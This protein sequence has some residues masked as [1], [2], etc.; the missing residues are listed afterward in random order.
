[1]IVPVVVE[2]QS[3]RWYGRIPEI[4]DNSIEFVQL[5]FRFPEDWDGM[6]IVAQFTQTQTYN[7][8]LVNNRCFLPME[9][10]AGPCEVSVFGYLN[11]E[12]TRGTTIPLKLN[13]SRSGFVSSAE[14]PIP[15]TPDLYA[16]L[17]E[18]FS[19]IAGSGGGGSGGGTINPED[20]AAAVEDY[21]SKNPPDV[22]DLS[23]EVSR[24]EE[25]ASNAEAAADRAEE[26]AKVTTDLDTTLT[27]EGKAADAKAV[28]DA[29]SKL[30]G[31]NVDYVLPV[32]GDELGG[33]KNGGNVT[34]NADGTMTAPENE[35]SG[36]QV[37]NAVSD[38][39][40]AH[41][42]ATTTV[43]AGSIDPNKTTWMKQA[44]HNIFDASTSSVGKGFYYSG[45]EM[46]DQAANSV[47]A[48]IPVKAGAIYRVV[49]VTN[50]R[51]LDS[52]KTCIGSQS[53]NGT[54]RLETA[55]EGAAYALMQYVTANA[56]S[57]QVHEY[58]GE[59]WKYDTY[60]NLRTIVITE[61]AYSKA[62][63]DVVERGFL[64]GSL[65]LQDGTV[66][67]DKTTWMRRVFHN[68]FDPNDP[69][70]Q[71]G[72]YYFT[73]GSDV[74]TG[75][76]T[77]NY[78]LSGYIPVIGGK[79]YHIN[80]N[81]H[82][83]FF[84]EAKKFLSTGSPKNVPD[85]ASYMRFS[86]QKS[87]MTVDT[88][89]VYE[90]IGEEWEYDTYKNLYSIV[91]TDPSYSGAIA[92]MVRGKFADG[93]LTP[94]NLFADESL[95]YKQ[96]KGWKEFHWNIVDPATVTRT[97][98]NQYYQYHTDFC[99]VEPGM[100][101]IGNYTYDFY[102]AN[103]EKVSSQA[104]FYDGGIHDVIVPDGVSFVKV[105]SGYE[106][107]ENGTIRILTPGYGKQR[108]DSDYDKSFPVFKDEDSKEG[109]K[110]YLGLYPW[111]GKNFGII[112]DS[113]TAP[114]TWCGIMADN[115]KAANCWNKAVSGANFGDVDGV[116]KTAYEQAQELVSAGNTLDVVLITMGTNDANNGRT[117]G[118]IVESNSISDFD[119]STYTG[120]LQA[121]LNCLQ[122]NFPEA[123]I[124]VGWTP[125]GGLVNGTKVEYITRMQEVCLMYGVEYIETRTCGV[126]R[127][128]DVY[129]ECYEGGTGGGH[130]TG[131]GQQK[132][133]EYMTRLMKSKL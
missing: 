70:I 20:I 119:L 100:T 109:F 3:L 12:V 62:I 110:V 91:I 89:Q 95:R 96:M 72:H 61:D 50:I 58:I 108:G 23:E 64:D 40:D 65:T 1:M 76:G 92:D 51:W 126:T 83:K 125:M 78:F 116:P 128:S 86:V 16:Q 77:A 44:H 71:D 32:G 99:E 53:A 82:L 47:S 27:Q 38:W 104:A 107:N 43:A 133:G 98:P 57:V 131:A 30:S 36:E 80:A 18:Y 54:D 63:A 124:Y 87:A 60:K 9:L 120:G 114:G 117:M 7:C 42:E 13:I 75:G 129:A 45:A 19:S 90:D 24:A 103:K 94:Y 52:A 46:N 106:T 115:L 4:A 66:N 11:E 37:S 105:T 88:E 35:I 111:E 68:I 22:P 121:C 123:I 113:F 17:I 132:I 15:P 56:E 102:D 101:L 85:E 93:S 122:N 118:E 130:P 2:G 28:G 39:L 74:V 55:P 6:I 33:V 69:D 5:E 49:N 10:V 127:F 112:G 8:L 97:Q 67:P 79:K 14:T 29:I 26:A 41:P 73:E 81:V 84:D 34:I 21:L 48:E 59:A 25:A 31:G